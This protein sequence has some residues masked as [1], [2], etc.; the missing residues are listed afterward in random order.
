MYILCRTFDG[1]FIRRRLEHVCEK[2][3]CIKTCGLTSSDVATCDAGADELADETDEV[4]DL[5]DDGD[6]HDV[7]ND[8]AKRNECRATEVLAVHSA[9]RKNVMS[10]YKSMVH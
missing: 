4:G 9:L 7:S 8:E 3:A 10:T 5:V 2:N 1:N 6:A